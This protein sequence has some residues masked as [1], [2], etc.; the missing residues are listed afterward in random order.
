MNLNVLLI[1]FTIFNTNYAFML[2]MSFKMMMGAGNDA[3]K[4]NNYF[5]NYIE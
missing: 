4:L 5:K 1:S 2:G 3:L